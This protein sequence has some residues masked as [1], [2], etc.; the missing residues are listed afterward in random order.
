MSLL[1]QDIANIQVKNKQND[2]DMFFSCFQVLVVVIS[3]YSCSVYF[4][5]EIPKPGALEGIKTPFS[6]LLKPKSISFEKQV[7]PSI[8]TT[9]P[10]PPARCPV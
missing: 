8:V 5:N 3:T 6:T 9:F 2:I 1:S 10:I 4:N 7:T